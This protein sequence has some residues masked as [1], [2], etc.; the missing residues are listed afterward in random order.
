MLHGDA[1]VYGCGRG[2]GYVVYLTCIHVKRSS[3]A[4]AIQSLIGPVQTASLF[5]LLQS[6][7]AGGVGLA[8]VN[9]MVPPERKGD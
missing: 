3:A 6:A 4:T 8:V 2:G 1:G 9:G 7:G 5:A